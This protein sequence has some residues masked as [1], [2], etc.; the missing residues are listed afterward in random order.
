MT[1]WRSQSG[2]TRGSDGTDGY[3][4]LF[5]VDNDVA[6]NEGNHQS[7]AY[8][9]F[10]FSD[11]R[12]NVTTF[13][14]SPNPLISFRDDGVTSTNVQTAPTGTGWIEDTTGSETVAANSLVNIEVLNQGGHGDDV[15]TSANL[16][17]FE[18]ASTNQP[19]VGGLGN[20][21]SSGVTA[22]LSFIGPQSPLAVEAE[23]NLRIKRAQTASNLRHIQVVQSS[24]GTVNTRINGVDSTNLVITVSGTGAYED[25]TGSDAYAAEDDGSIEY[26]NTDTMDSFGGYYQLDLNTAESWWGHHSDSFTTRE[27]KPFIVGFLGN[28]TADDNYFARI[29]STTAGNL[30]TYVTAAGSGTRDYTLRIGSTNST[31]LTIAIT[32]TGLFEDTT[33]SEA[34]ADTDSVVATMASTGGSVSISRGAVELPWSAVGAPTVFPRPPIM[35]RQAVN[36]AAVI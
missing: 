13:T 32:G 9:A 24:S 8:T 27:Y 26:D 23:A 10:T 6:S 34:I 1:Q 22:F 19:F 14:G 25:V 2:G 18:H 15:H 12:S 7:K 3:V 21:I 29:G 36:R 17:T 31:N 4:A 33:G 30:Q 28:T 16:I 11:L 35:I 20:S 5:D